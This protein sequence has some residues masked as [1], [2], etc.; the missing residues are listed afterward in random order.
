M[1]AGSE[2]GDH[3]SNALR[4]RMSSLRHHPPLAIRFLRT[5]NS[6]KST[7]DAGCASSFAVAGRASPLAPAR[8]MKLLRNPTVTRDDVY[9]VISRYPFAFPT[10]SMQTYSN[11]GFWLLG[12]I[13]EKAS[14]MTYEKYVEKRI[15]EP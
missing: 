15:F 5:V 11:S 3:T 8:A 7:R 10:G 6:S 14:G 1:A 2:Q 9:K 4:P 13:I 12:L